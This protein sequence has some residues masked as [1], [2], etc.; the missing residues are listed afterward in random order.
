[1]DSLKTLM[2]KNQYDLVIKLTENSDDSVSLFYRLTAF[3]AVGQVDEALNIILTKREILK[4]QLNLL[5]KFHIETLCIKGL[6]DEAYQALKYYENLPYENQEV[7]ETLRAMPQY[8]RNAEKESLR[9]KNIDED[10][11]NKRLMSNND[12]EVL[13]ALDTIKSLSLNS[14]IKNIIN[15]MQSYPRQIIRTFALLLLVHSHYD[16]EVEFLHQSQIIKVNPSLLPE[17]FEV[18]GFKDLNAITN[19]MLKEYRDPTIMQNALQ[20]L[21]SYL[22]YLYPDPYR[23]NKVE[24]LLIFGYVAKQLL[25]IDTSDLEDV[26]KQKGLDFNRINQLIRDINAI[27]KEF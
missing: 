1:M 7:E 20:S 27:L 14:F 19:A 18:P 17:P 10:E 3:V 22:I 4:E 8:I 13:G 23:F 12:E 2:E 24:T 9:S 11:L 6:F 25:Q 16:K 26:C 5:I 21:S 15:L